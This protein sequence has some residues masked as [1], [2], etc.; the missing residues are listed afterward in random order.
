R[1]RRQGEQG[2]LVDE[3]GEIDLVAVVVR[4]ADVLLAESPGR[5]CRGGRRGEYD[6]ERDVE[7]EGIVA[8]AACAPTIDGG[9]YRALHEH[10]EP[11]AMVRDIDRQALGQP[12]VP[13]AARQLQVERI[14]VLHVGDR[15]G[16]LPDLF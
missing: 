15:P 13:G 14:D 12:V 7:G 6:R 11:R 1:A 2:L 10:V 8:E 4:E 3:R 9:P 5:R 16:R